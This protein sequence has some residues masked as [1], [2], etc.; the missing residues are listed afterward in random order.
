MPW[1]NKFKLELFKVQ[2][3]QYVV[4]INLVRELKS[5]WML[6]VTLRE[7]LKGLM[8]ILKALHN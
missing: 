8:M 6:E 2:N 3:L 4:D 1:N 7:E 5:L